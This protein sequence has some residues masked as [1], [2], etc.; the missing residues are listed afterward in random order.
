MTLVPETFRTPEAP[1][2]PK[3]PKAPEA[4]EEP[5]GPEAPKALDRLTLEKQLLYV[6]DEHKRCSRSIFVDEL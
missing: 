1:E 5:E 6:T 2:A 4:P 3:A